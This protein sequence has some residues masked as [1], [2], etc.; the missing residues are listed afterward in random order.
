MRN[1][2]A[3][4]IIKR[5]GRSSAREKTSSRPFQPG[6]L[7]SKRRRMWVPFLT[8]AE[9]HICGKEHPPFSRVRKQVVCVRR[10]CLHARKHTC[11]GCAAVH[12]HTHARFLPARMN[13]AGWGRLNAMRTLLIF[14]IFNMFFTLI[15]PRR[16]LLQIKVHMKN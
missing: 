14:P 7:L 2:W 4:R 6:Q 11:A 1:S 16:T 12:S 3:W 9:T 5:D 15:F 8:C 10:P 13:C